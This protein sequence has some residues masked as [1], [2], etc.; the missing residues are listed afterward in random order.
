MN[1]KYWYISRSSTCRMTL[2]R[3]ITLLIRIGEVL[4]NRLESI[5]DL[6][7]MINSHVTTANI[8]TSLFKIRQMINLAKD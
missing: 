8:T 7:Y 1:I 5:S 3:P 2:C 4:P 6:W